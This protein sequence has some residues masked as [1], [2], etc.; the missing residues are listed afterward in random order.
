M[1]ASWNRDGLDAGEDRPAPLA[2]LPAQKQ[3]TAGLRLDGRAGDVGPENPRNCIDG[4]QIRQIFPCREAAHIF[5][6]DALLRPALDARAAA[7]IVGLRSL[8]HTPRKAKQ[9]RLAEAGTNVRGGIQGFLRFVKI[10]GRHGYLVHHESPYLVESPSISLEPCTS[11]SPAS[12][13]TSV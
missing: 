12:S 2:A 11:C 6:F 9:R 13:M 10:D 8:R 7:Q 4:A 1:H 3:K 5:I